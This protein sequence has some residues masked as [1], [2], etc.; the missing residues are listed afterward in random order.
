MQ[1]T[2]EEL[3]A[4]AV[5]YFKLKL[6]GKNPVAQFITPEGRWVDDPTPF[7]S[8]CKRAWRIKPELVQH[9]GG[10]YPAPCA[11]AEKV[12][13]NGGAHVPFLNLCDSGSGSGYL[14]PDERMVFITDINRAQ[15]LVDSNL[16]YLNERDAIARAKVIYEID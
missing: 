4:I 8:F 11:D 2:K 14:V 1:Q 7:F 13:E 3:W 6:E 5:E 9:K 10:E 15:K 16:A 12:F